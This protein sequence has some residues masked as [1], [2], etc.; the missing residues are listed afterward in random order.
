[1]TANIKNSSPGSLAKLLGWT[2]I[3]AFVLI[4]GCYIYGSFGIINK[5]SFSDDEGQLAG[6]AWIRCAIE[7]YVAQKGALPASLYEEGL[8][9]GTTN[10]QAGP[11]AD[12][13]RITYRIIES[14]SEKSK[15][16]CPKSDAACEGLITANN[17]FLYEL[18]TNFKM[19]TGD[20][21]RAIMRLPT[22]SSFP[23]SDHCG[24]DIYD[25]NPKHSKGKHCYIFYSSI[26]EKNYPVFIK[27]LNSYDDF[28]DKYSYD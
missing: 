17:F 5:E 11:F 20:E 21:E 19:D 4:L 16:I 28:Y 7:E 10:A 14:P 1:M 9:V 22:E 13:S 6:I 26:E 25:L 8:R 27:Q 2:Y 12:S 18:C 3:Y 15:L 23:S 24:R